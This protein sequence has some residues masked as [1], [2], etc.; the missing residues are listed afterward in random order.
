MR[1]SGKRGP[2]GSPRARGN[3][4][5]RR[6]EAP[7][8]NATPTS[9]AATPYIGATEMGRTQC[10]LPPV[11]WTSSEVRDGRLSCLWICS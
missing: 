5:T 10:E 9:D 6:I 7:R 4:D 11:S 1:L 2:Y 3:D 8:T